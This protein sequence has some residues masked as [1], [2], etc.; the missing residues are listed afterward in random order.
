MDI[1]CYEWHVTCIADWDYSG[2]TPDD[3][4][5]DLFFRSWRDGEARADA[6]HSGGAPDDADIYAFFDAWNAGC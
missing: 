2:S 5:I 3:R 4:D 6:N 1:G